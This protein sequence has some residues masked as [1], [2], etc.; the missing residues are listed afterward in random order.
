[1]DPLRRNHWQSPS[2]T[3]GPGLPWPTGRSKRS[4]AYPHP[5]PRAARPAP[6]T[7]PIPPG[8]QSHARPRPAQQPY[9]RN[10]P[11]RHCRRSTQKVP[12]A[13]HHSRLKGRRILLL[14]IQW[15]RQSQVSRL[16][17]QMR[18]SSVHLLLLVANRQPLFASRSQRQEPQ[19]KERL[20]LER[21]LPQFRQLPWTKCL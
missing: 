17:L 11:C 7:S 15:H 5:R 16:H 10:R 12:H 9:S 3:P 6:S 1:M 2:D 19:P 18:R 8:S 21:P 4:P 14:R 20:C 13:R